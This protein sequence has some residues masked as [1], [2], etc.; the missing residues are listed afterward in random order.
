MLPVFLLV[1][2]IAV[3]PVCLL[4][5]QSVMEGA[6]AETARLLITSDERDDEAVRAYAL[7]RLAAV[8]DIPIF[9]QG[10]PLAWEVACEAGQGS[11]GVTIR[12]AVRP[13][14]VLGMIAGLWGERNAQGD[15]MVE[16]SVSYAG[17]PSWL[18]GDYEAWTMAWN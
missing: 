18:E 1:L 6:A 15:V 4:Y 8:P 11:V 14:P 5:T 10:G 16:T 12:G 13:L 2:L 17:R 3:E 7:R 9:H